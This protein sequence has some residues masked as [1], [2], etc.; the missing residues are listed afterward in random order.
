MH[1]QHDSF[2][3]V[4]G[5]AQ[6]LCL[7]LAR[8]LSIA[9]FNPCAWL[10]RTCL[11]TRY[12]T[13]VQQTV[14]S[15]ICRM[16]L[17]KFPSKTSS[18]ATTQLVYVFARTTHEVSGHAQT[19]F[20]FCFLNQSQQ[21]FHFVFSN[22]FHLGHSIDASVSF[23]ARLNT[24]ASQCVGGEQDGRKRA[25]P[26][27]APLERG[28]Y[29]CPSRCVRTQDLDVPSGMTSALADQVGGPDENVDYAEF[30]EYFTVSLSLSRAFPTLPL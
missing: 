26:I 8:P 13:G 14:S 25:A 30:E 24:A 6:D 9:R 4:D 5:G 11:Y 29:S 28:R 22:N 20:S 23:L 7:R 2:S 15:N 18:C 16:G 19:A 12:L 3:R 21:L 10:V 1:V 27:Q 17:V